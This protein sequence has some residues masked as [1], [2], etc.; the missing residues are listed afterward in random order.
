MGEMES[1]ICTL[2]GYDPHLQAGDCRF[3]VEAAEHAVA[4]FPRYLRHAKGRHAGQ[5]FELAPWQKSVV[6]NLYGWKRPD[7]SRRYRECLVYVAKKNGK[8]AFGAGLSLYHLTND[9]EYG[10][11]LYSAAASRDQASIL[12]SYMVG[13]IRQSDELK[14]ILEV[15]GGKGGSITKAVVY[16]D[17]FSSYKCLSADA[18]T[19]DGSNASFAVI[20]EI[21]RHKN[22]ELT[23]VLW[24]GTAARHQPLFLYTT[25]ADCNQ[26]SL[27]ND[28]HAKAKAV[29]ANKGDPHHPGYDPSFLP[30]IFEASKEDNWRDPATWH[31]ANPNLGV[32][33]PM[34]FFEREVLKAEET[35]A[36]L[37]NFLRLHLNIVTDA[38]VIWIS[39][40]RWD[41]CKHED[42][43]LGDFRG[44]PCY[45]GLDLAMRSD[46]TALSLV[47][48]P[49]DGR[50]EWCV[51]GDIWLPRGSVKRL[52]NKNH[53]PYDSWAR[54]GH[55]RLTEGEITD[56]RHIRS[57]V[58]QYATQFEVRE[59]A[60][61]PYNAS[62]LATEM[63][64]DGLIMTE[65]KQS[66]P[67]LS[68][69]AKFFHGMVISK[70][71]AHS[72]CPVKRWQVSS[73]VADVDQKGDIILHKKKSGHKIDWVVATVMAISRAMVA[74]DGTCVYEE[75]GLR[76]L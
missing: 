39:G 21:H 48:P 20:D 70:K 46:T 45:M 59:I 13:M 7:G 8:T 3:D 4:F 58:Q 64:E 73:V 74:V 42:L 63:I 2:P 35:P 62:H 53:V 14:E 5:P 52:I 1:I 60:F 25:T 29:C 75:R 65:V 15:Y 10:A 24:G 19:A 69:A 32:T 76:W 67:A 71:I 51:F 43:S 22:R 61:D 11:E 41:E 30:V 34:D 44:Q 33:I 68:E 56:Y 17:W 49:V 36:Q 23:D 38:D 66:R 50:D 26:P 27:C 9:A 55:L 28:M 40:E 12:F 57:C 6:A 18:N 16:D 37:T 31:L 72:G 47:F 54:A